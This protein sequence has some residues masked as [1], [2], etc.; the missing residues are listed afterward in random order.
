MGDSKQKQK[1]NLEGLLKFAVKK[2]VSDIH[3]KAGRPP[4]FRTG[5]SVE[6]VGP[7]GM[8]LLNNDEIMRLFADL[9]QDYHQVL[10]RE[11]GSVDFGWGIEGLGR[12]RINLFRSR[13]GNQ[14]VMRV[15][16]ARIPTLNEL[17]LPK[18]MEK[19]LEERRGLVF[20]TGAAG[21][22]KSTTLAAIADQINRVRACHIITIEDPIEYMIMDRKALITQREVGADT[23][24]FQDGLRAALRQDPD[25]IIVGEARDRETIETA[26]I[27]AETGHLV[28]S[29][30]H[31]IDARETV[32]R[33]TSVFNEHEREHARLIL[34]SV[35]RA[36]VS[37]R[38]VG[39]TDGKA[40]VPAV[41]VMLVTARIRDLLK[42]AEGKDELH[43]AISKGHSQYG[44]QTFDQ[45]L[46]QLYKDGMITLDMAM[47]HCSN[48]A[49]FALLVKGI[50]SRSGE[51]IESIDSEK[52]QR[53]KLEI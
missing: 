36:V 5:A 42:T 53:G 26:L 7:K 6:L 25:V 23:P 13:T 29:T 2:A 28:L 52:F 14:A 43:E 20:I 37:Q 24:A 16:P 40:R 4:I 18:V 10:F 33:V 41:E 49:D 35:L 30:M 17:G 44:M 47:E 11:R 8:E 38:L 50:Y 51:G 12:F 15:I 21:Q 3:L 48:P 39:Q 45:S 19:I 1:L 31:T 46:M 32:N 34:A 22:G 27:A 9:M